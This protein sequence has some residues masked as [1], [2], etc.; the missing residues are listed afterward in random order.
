MGAQRI[1]IVSIE[2]INWSDP[3]CAFVHSLA[4][5]LCTAFNSLLREEFYFEGPIATISRIYS[6]SLSHL[7]QTVNHSNSLFLCDRRGRASGHLL[8][9]MSTLRAQCSPQTRDYEQKS[10]LYFG[11]WRHD[12]RGA[13]CINW[14]VNIQQSPWGCSP[15]TF[16]ILISASGPVD[17]H[18]NECKMN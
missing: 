8:F 17:E 10:R 16:V 3:K 1:V 18:L 12:S 13:D 7:T 15:S 9:F 14:S 5:R 2:V 11:N 4:Y 6:V